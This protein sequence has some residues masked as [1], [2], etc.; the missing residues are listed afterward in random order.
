MSYLP[1]CHKKMEKTWSIFS[2]GSEMKGGVT[3]PHRAAG[4]WCGT[5]CREGTWPWRVWETTAMR[6]C[7]LPDS[8]HWNGCAGPAA[9][10]GV[11][12]R[13]SGGET[14]RRFI[15]CPKHNLEHVLYDLIISALS[16][17]DVIMQKQWQDRRLSTKQKIEE[18]KDR[19]VINKYHDHLSLT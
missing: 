15:P 8:G 2:F 19:V 9:A 6:T 7:E 11:T 5:P 17:F 12:A 10:P 13:D 3:V 16:A 4:Q 14:G 1:Q 18:N